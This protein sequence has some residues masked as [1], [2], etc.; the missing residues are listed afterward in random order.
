MSSVMKRNSIILIALFLAVMTIIG[1]GEETA[2]SARTP[3]EALAR[4]KEGNARFANGTPLHPHT[5]TARL[6]QAESENQGDHAFAT[7]IAC[8]DSRVPVERI[9]DAGVMDLFVIRGAG[10]IVQH[11]EAGS[12]EYGLAHVHTPL[13]VVLGHTQCGAVT[14]ATSTVQGHTHTFERNIPHL[15]TPIIP[16]VTK[17]IADHPTLKGKELVHAAIKNN[18]WQ[19]IHDLFMKS[20]AT[21]TLV[22]QGNVHVYGAIYDVG[23]GEVQWL[24]EDRPLEIL[25]AVQKNPERAMNAFADSTALMPEAA[26][27]PAAP[28]VPAEEA[29]QEHL[30]HDGEKHSEHQATQ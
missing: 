7:V 28:Q 19:S 24:D 16:A 17:T 3:E 13:L 4:L 23:T 30:Q 18:V 11:T 5:S 1:S 9:F 20:P 25:K 10:N 2:P 8:S 29:V 12:I 22:E 27:A 14:A 15:L 6:Q 26:S 21:R